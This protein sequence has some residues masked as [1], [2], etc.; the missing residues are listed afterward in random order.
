MEDIIATQ[1]QL[2][3]SIESVYTNFK[4]DGAERKTYSNI[5]R[6]ISTLE[7]Y[8]NEFNS[9]HMQLV[10]YQNVEHDYFKRNHYQRT[11]DYFQELVQYLQLYCL[12]TEDPSAHEMPERPQLNKL[13][14]LETS[15]LKPS[16]SPSGRSA[17]TPPPPPAATITSDNDTYVNAPALPVPQLRSQQS[18]NLK[19]MK[20]SS[21]SSKLDEMLRKQKSNFKAFARTVTNI[22]LQNISEKWE[23]E[24]IL[25][26]IETRWTA[27]DHLHWEIDSEL[28]EEDKEYERS[29][30][31]YERE[32]NDI[33]K[34]LNQKM[35][36]ASFRTH[37]TP[38]MDIPTFNGDYHKWV[39]FKDLFLEAIHN[40]R[41]MSN[42]QKMQF[43]K[44]KVKGEAEKLIQ[45]L[46]ISTENY[47]I[48]WDILNH[49]F[50]NR[51][52]IF[53]SHI[54]ILMSL[55]AMQLQT[56]PLIKKIHD[57]AN[58][59]LNAIKS[60]GVD[61]TTWDPL[62][63]HI[64]SQKLDSE[65]H[66]DYIESLKT[67]RELPT[68]SE[69]FEFLEN[70][71]TSLEASKRKQDNI[72]QKPNTQNP[73][74]TAKRSNQQNYFNYNKYS[75]SNAHQPSKQ[76]GKALF[77][78]STVRCPLCK[79]KHGIFNCKDFLEMSSE[80]K[81]KTVNN[82]RICINCLYDHKG[83]KCISTKSCSKCTKQ[84]NTLLHDSFTKPSSSVE[85]KHTESVHVSQQKASEILLATALIKVLAADG[86]HHTMRALID[87]GSQI[88][89]ITEN[90]AQ[91]LHAPRRRCKGVVFGLGAKE[92][93]S[94][95]STQI[96]AA[97]IHSDFTFSTDVIIMN[98]LINNLPNQSFSKPS[99]PHI[100]HIKLADPEFYISRPVDLLLG[101]DIYSLIM[102]GGIIK[103]DNDTQPIAQ[104]TQ[105]G[106]LLCGNVKTYQ[107]NVILNNIDDIQR[108]WSI[109][110]IADSSENNS[111]EDHH[112]VQVYK[113]QTTRQ[114]DGRYIVRLPMKPDAMQKLGESKQRA[115]AQFRQ[116]EKKL[117][118]NEKLS[119]DYKTFI[120]EYIKLGHMQNVNKGDGNQTPSYYLPHHCVIRPDSDTTALRV[121][122]NASSPTSSGLSLNDLMFSGPNLQQ[123]LLSLILK[124][125]QFEIAFTA[126]IEKMFRQINLH[127]DDQNLHKIYWRD[128]STSK[129]QNNNQKQVL[130]EYKLTTVTY[131]TKAAPFLAM[132]TLKQLASDEGHKYSNRAKQALENEF[133]MDDLL[134]GSHNID[135]ALQL[136]TDLIA[137]LKSGGF[138]LRKWS[139][140]N[141]D[142][143]KGNEPTTNQTSF[144]FK[145]PESTKALGLR[146]NPQEDV[147]LFQFQ[148]NTAPKLLT[149]RLLLS[150]ISKV[151]D[152]LGW[153]SPV[154]T[155]L[156]L[157]F[158]TVW[159]HDIHWN[160]ELPEEI[161]KEWKSISQD[162]ENI[163]QIK[164]QRWI[165][166]HE[167][168]TIELHGF[169]DSSTKA[170]ACVVY[171]KINLQNQINTERSS[172]TIGAAKAR[173]VPVKKNITLPRLELMSCLL[174]SK[175]METLVSTLP[176]YNIKMF[177]WTDSTAALGWIKGDSNRWKAFVANRVEQIKAIMPPECWRHVK[178]QDNPADCASRGITVKQLQ[179]HALWWNG[180]SWLTSF[181]PENHNDNLIYVTDQE[182][183]QQTK[184]HSTTAV[185]TI[186]Q[187][188]IIYDITS[189]HSNFIHVTRVL[190]WIL[191]AVSRNQ[192]LQEKQFYLSVD[193]LSRAKHMI[194]KYYQ[195]LEFTEE[196]NSL[197]NQEKINPKSKILNLNPFLDR[198]GLL[199]VGGRIKH[200]QIKEDMKHPLIIPHSGHITDLLIDQAHRK[201]FHGGTRLTLSHIRQQYWVI[202]GNRA[203]KKHIRSCVICRR[204][205]PEKQKQL[206]GDLPAARS[207]PTRPFYNCGV[208]FTGYVDVK[209]NKGRGVKTTKGYIS[210]FVCMVTKAVH[211]ELV[212]DLSSSAFLAALRRMAARRGAPRHIYCDNGTNFVG[213]SRILQHEYLNL[214]EILDKEFYS[215]IADMQIEFHFNAPSWPSAG[216][217]WE[218]AVKSLK[219]HLRRVLGEQ[220]LTYEEYS[221]LLAQI[222]AC[223]NTRPLCAITEDPED[224]DFLTPSHFLAS[225]PTLSI[226]ETERDERTRWQL[227]Q[228]IFNDLWKRWQ[229]EYLCQLSTRTKWQQSQQNQNIGDIVVIQD[230]NLPPGK[231]SLGRV[232]ELHPGKDGHVRVVSL[233]TKNGIIQR[234]IVKLSKL[235][236]EPQN[237][238]PVQAQ[239]NVQLQLN[240]QL[241][242]TSSKP[243]KGISATL[244]TMAITL[245][246]MMLIL[247]THCAYN[248]VRL[249]DKQ[250]VYFDKIS[251]MQLARD[252]W[253]L[254][255][256]YDMIPYWE[257]AEIISKYINNLELLCD[258]NKEPL[259]ETIMT[260]ILHGYT[261]LDH[262]NHL[263]LGQQF[264]DV[265]PTRAR[266]G[267]INGVGSIARSL[268]GVLDDQF[269]EQYQ[270]DIELL[271]M[272]Q[273]HMGL[274]W[275]NQTSVVEAEHNLL[276]R[277][278]AT[279]NKQHKLIN[280]HIINIQKTMNSMKKDIQDITN[281]NDF[282]LSAIIV[283]NVLLNLQNVQDKL[284]DTIADLHHGSFNVHLLSP[285]QLRNELNIISGQISKQDLAL[286]I[287]NMLSDLP[288]LYHLLKVKA[289]MTRDYFIFEIRL[290]LVTRD[291]FEIYKLIPIQHK[292]ENNMIKVKLVADY[293]GINI[294]KDSYVT[295][296]QEDVQDC[297]Q[298]NEDT[299]LCLLQRPVY[300]MTS[301]NSLC[302]RSDVSTEC[303][304]NIESCKSTWSE[305][306]AV[307]T[308]L[309]SCCNPCATRIICETQ[310]SSEKLNGS[311]IIT[312][313]EGCSIKSDT[314]TIYSHKQRENSL[315][316]EADILKI[317]IPP[318]N[319]IIELTLPTYNKT[320]IS[321]PTNESYLD[322]QYFQEQSK[323]INNRIQQLKNAETEIQPAYSMASSHDIT[324]YVLINII[325]GIICITGIIFAWRRIRRCRI[326][327]VGA[328]RS[329]GDDVTHTAT[330]APSPPP[331]PAAGAAAPPPVAR[332]A[333]RVQ[334]LASATSQQQPASGPSDQED[335]ELDDLTYARV[336]K[337]TSPHFYN[338]F[339][340]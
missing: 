186:N 33:K 108:F 70:K 297:S 317:N 72:A 59:C 28:Y 230:A 217:L 35:W 184:V 100:E 27:I 158:Q 153:L 173:L 134:S 34:V 25:K 131:G 103:G 219:H 283:N 332:R 80:M 264:D 300:H 148:L 262:Y 204:Q 326:N 227:T 64:L 319:H 65:T 176:N 110:D 239:Q 167:N 336:H 166:S 198:E 164:V 183:K 38:T 299:Y 66:K 9:N 259:C 244:K 144:D 127:S 57:T 258:K 56:A 247:P 308:Y 94:K 149:K 159:L 20:H 10:D 14:V 6:R 225:G 49:R 156:K 126:D 123:D 73:S 7:A 128:P 250:A 51:K 294:Q 207:N 257:G 163:N 277:V 48:C 287:N 292:A 321:N 82:L 185:T 93:S 41:S 235:P 251:S 273:R 115:I 268:F 12:Y 96:T 327:S 53:S 205:N 15:K 255:V 104:Q 171:Y 60:L 76:F 117:E 88:S 339:N 304:T 84:H 111:F 325:L 234:P 270:R 328:T 3:Q 30:N 58:E 266:R 16:L 139:S 229:I 112:C 203:V 218:A 237:N 50:N 335:I 1:Y 119:F 102:M 301:D 155:K 206:M 99:W 150:E 42:A 337:A 274:L 23:F 253:K 69:F 187:N 2:M 55:P 91:R 8:W 83:N 168:D 136:K 302:V 252:E 286:P 74:F 146:W 161:S 190:A 236:I 306:H 90:A 323:S 272:N 315:H 228:K 13:L 62:V 197:Q 147:L 245:L 211:L 215:Q 71:F 231:W 195:H 224:I 248:I 314:F 106:W 310:V 31:I 267:L 223:L 216:G 113:E 202:G 196:I 29:F 26:H 17:V 165:R 329:A 129:T 284:L 340:N 238:Y 179:Q 152:P 182:T 334:F 114:S 213:A 311:G 212:S 109:E 243:K 282:A 331:A 21:T 318:I 107:C 276:Q 208:D 201:T 307:N 200:A 293:V 142:L 105:L 278:E 220:K 338:H 125:R 330:R 24:D 279:M 145:H 77:V 312:L 151:F 256:F 97:A 288:K 246:T 85:F 226:I 43:L 130:Q 316:T 269:A 18:S 75:T 192:R 46:N 95:G 175:L 122:F 40:N 290:P 5:R 188:N 132:M 121:V 11:K 233:K 140:N 177:G 169:C 295:M 275:K 157:L 191:R 143:L 280:Q 333:R 296:T 241:S 210:V 135:S 309:F 92:N 222:E 47:Q 116:L 298:Y 320:D 44:T 285:K 265:A 170:Y 36:S 189:K 133:Y 291:H 120:D 199:R 221:T 162:L 39:S 87:Q 61:I 160:S 261:E 194:I 249:K 305:L 324:Q 209:T 289:K 54:N 101:A 89:L 240:N 22:D 281:K 52:L 181:S 137:L 79:G 37:S 32:Y 178:S 68:L 154:T 138:N 45:H 303:V 67:P 19:E 254:I 263:L 174:L 172:V 271:R 214:Q 193:E 260:Q 242:N 141:T 81:L 180:P 4:K 232:V 86:T 313:S 98:N 78:S 322:H 118:R 63:V 124:W